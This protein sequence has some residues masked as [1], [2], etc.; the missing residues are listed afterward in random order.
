MIDRLDLRRK[1]QVTPKALAASQT[2]C[3]D[4]RPFHHVDAIYNGAIDTKA[5]A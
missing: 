1:G 3:P 5:L 2:S 4:T